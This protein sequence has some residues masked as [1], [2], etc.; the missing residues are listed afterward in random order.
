MIRSRNF[1]L[2]LVVLLVF[3]AIVDL[4]PALRNLTYGS[5]GAPP[6]LGA[7]EM[8][9][10]PFWASIMFIFLSVATLFGAYGLWIGQKWGKVVTLIT[11]PIGLL[12]AL[13]DVVGT[14][15]VGIYPF[16]ALMSVY[17]VASIVVIYLVLRRQPKPAL[18]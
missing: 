6:L 12:F 15:A 7:E 8:D 10:P 3:V 13:G 14:L 17:V 11:R 9:G 5:A 4:I 16:A 2:L 18:A 1:T